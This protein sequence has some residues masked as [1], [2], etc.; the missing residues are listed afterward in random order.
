MWE[1]I[2]NNGLLDFMNDYFAFFEGRKHETI[3]IHTKSNYYDIVRSECYIKSNGFNYKLLTD[4]LDDIYEGHQDNFN[5]LIFK[6][7]DKYFKAKLSIKIFD[8]II[9]LYI[10]ITG[11]TRT[12]FYI[13]ALDK[14]EIKISENCK[15]FQRIKTKVVSLQT[16][17][18]NVIAKNDLQYSL[19]PCL[20]SAVELLRPIYK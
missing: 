9:F 12:R 14:T 11:Y 4:D 16:L 13:I 3:K 19:P 1:S 10:L 2:E 18:L 8:S 5:L 17:C 6:A 15:L 7:E 20:S